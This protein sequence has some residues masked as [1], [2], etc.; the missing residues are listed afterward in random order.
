MAEMS[1]QVPRS[2]SGAPPEAGR[3]QL[4]LEKLGVIFG[5]LLGLA[6]AAG[7]LG[8]AL[9]GMGA[10][11]GLVFGAIALTVAATT[12]FGLFAAAVLSRKLNA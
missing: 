5:F 11:E 12:R 7:S 2:A 10:P 3:Q 8:E 9:S 6:V 1:C 4:F